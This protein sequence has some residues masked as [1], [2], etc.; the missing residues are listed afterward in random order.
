MGRYTL[1]VNET[2]VDKFSKVDLQKIDAYTTRFTSGKEILESLN[3]SGSLSVSYIF[4]K[5][6]RQ[7]ELAYNDKAYLTDLTYDSTKKIDN[8]NKVFQKY[9]RLFLENLRHDEFYDMVKKS[10]LFHSKIKEYV[11]L[12]VNNGDQ[13]SVNKLNEY[14][15]NYLQFRNIIF[16]LEQYDYYLAEKYARKKRMEVKIEQVFEEEHQEEF[17]TEED[18]S[19]YGE[20][21]ESHNI[22]LPDSMKKEKT[23]PWKN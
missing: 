3:L 6:E 19:K 15:S 12:Y 1:K 23:Y 20:Y 4:N 7:I 16:I 22:P 13:F 18:Y 14:L 9:V 8:R 10:N 21:I 11:D 2:I 5:E 17:F